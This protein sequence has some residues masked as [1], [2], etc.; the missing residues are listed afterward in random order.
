MK[1]KQIKLAALT[2]AVAAGVMVQPVKARAEEA[3]E[4]SAAPETENTSAQEQAAEAAAPAQSSEEIVAGNEAIADSNQETVNDN[5]STDEAQDTGAQTPAEGTAEV[6][7]SESGETDPEEKDSA[8]A[9]A[10]G[11]KETNEDGKEDPEKK[12]A[13]ET[14]ASED[15][16]DKEAGSKETDTA[17]K[18]DPDKKQQA[19]A[20]IAAGDK[21]KDL[22]Q[23]GSSVTDYNEAVKD[24]NDAAKDYNDTVTKEN[25]SK[26][27]DAAL[28]EAK[29]ALDAAQDAVKK[30]QEAVDAAA[31]MEERNA[32]IEELNKAVEK[33][34]EAAKAYSDRVNAL[35]EAKKDEVTDGNKDQLGKNDEALNG[36]QT[37]QDKNEAAGADADP[38]VQKAKEE[39]AQK[40]DQL[41][42]AKEAL[43]NATQEEYDA[44]VRAYNDAL[45]AYN[46]AADKYNDAVKA[47]KDKLAYADQNKYYE[48]LDKANADK[49]KELDKE[50]ADNPTVDSAADNKST[51]DDLEKELDKITSEDAEL[52]T[53]KTGLTKKKGDLLGQISKIDGIRAELE[54][55]KDAAAG[56]N[57]TLDSIKAYN[58]KVDAYNAAVE[59]YSS[60]LDD[61]NAFVLSYNNWQDKQNQ[62]ATGSADWG[63]IVSDSIAFKQ[64]Y[65][66]GTLL[67]HLDVKL[68]AAQ[69]LKKDEETGL[70]GPSGGTA[71]GYNHIVG[72]YESKEAYE[73]D[74]DKYGLTYK[75]DKDS[76]LS[77]NTPGRKDNEFTVR[78]DDSLRLDKDTSTVRFY[79]VMKNDAGDITGFDVSLDASKVYPK[80]TYYGG[81]KAESLAGY[82]DKE[83]NSLPT[84][85]VQNPTTG[86]METYYDI[87]GM[88]IY[89]VSAM[90]CDRFFWGADDANEYD[91]THLWWPDTR[92]DYA[93]KDDIK[94][95]NYKTVTDEETGEKIP[96]LKKANGLDLVLNLDTLIAL[97]QQNNIKTLKY[98][99]YEQYLT[100]QTKT[101][102]LAKLTGLTD[103]SQTDEAGLNDV[104]QQMKQLQQ[105][106]DIPETPDEPTPDPVPVPGTPET[107]VAPG[108]TPE[109]PVSPAEVPETPA[110]DTPVMPE[111]VQN[112]VENARPEHNTAASV[113]SHEATLPQT[114]VNRAGVL[115]LALA[116]FSFFAAGLGM[117]LSA[118]RGKHCKH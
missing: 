46:T 94:P 32:L 65:N 71:N 1:N 38:G 84:I 42:S 23:S 35:Q 111:T 78:N 61:Y 7:S 21:V 2:V 3:P 4:T 18:A 99:G 39:L 58:E 79:I 22:G 117:E 47:Y 31:S 36:N 14:G 67:S 89:A 51:L 24:R 82:R 37:A 108:E 33:Q 107:P 29:A 91:K 109:T 98:L 86:K 70:W 104:L 28:V 64:F 26:T 59:A 116:G 114:G 53:I 20:V 19:D 43:E 74:A 30:A 95:G 96:V 55:L 102:E 66:K 88:S 56:G 87:G 101:E 90:T 17:D 63:N 83:G 10:S 60:L 73:K 57:G 62:S 93:S 11:D 16:K 9:G 8:D 40:E 27:D 54:V 15:G 68:D 118:R 12:D 103:Y 52:E 77:S 106:L 76:A 5:A 48:D 105:E 50:S 25:E 49:N 97:A 92:L 100:P 81:A 69:D 41:N 115:G 72:I 45:S 85:K 80:G 44:A 113:G 112:P 13:E 110:A 34:N 75:N 6:G